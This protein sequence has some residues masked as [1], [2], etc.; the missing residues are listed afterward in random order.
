MD[1]LITKEGLDPEWDHL[2]EALPDNIYHQSSL[3]AKA[4]ASLGWKHLRLVVRENGK[5]V[6]GVQMLMRPLPLIGTVGYVARGPVSASRD[7]ALRRFILDQLDRVACAEH[8]LFLKIQPAYGEEDWAQR[9]LERGARPSGI[10]VTPLATHRIDLRQEPE[11]IL[12]NMH[13]KT[14]YNIRRAERKGLMVRQGTESDL[15]AFLR[16]EK[17]HFERLGA[18]PEPDNYHYDMYAL[19][20]PPGYFSF[21]LVEYEGEAMAAG[22]FM[23]FGDTTVNKLLVDSN[24]LRELNPQSLLHWQVMLWAKERGIAWYD[25]GGV[26]LQIA[27]AL[28]SNA[29]IPN[30]RAARVARFKHSFGGQVIFRPGVYDLSYV[31]PRRLT[32]RM[33]PG[34]IKIKPLLSALVGGRLS[35]YIQIHDRA[36]RKVAVQHGDENDAHENGQGQEK[37]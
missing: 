9:L 30:T 27:K 19:L 8:V 20:S 4:Q 33:V 36:A 31:W 34:L 23:T 11:A 25:F 22:T 1:V 14:R 12:G 3:Y 26:D 15:P 13:Y 7:P 2:L 6:G 5:I 10:R 32:I 35:G 29:P 24:Q 21:A 18:T 28:S 17:A 16:L 37:A